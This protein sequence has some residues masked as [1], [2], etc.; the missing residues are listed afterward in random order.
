M[1]TFYQTTRAEVIEAGV[2]FEYSVNQILCF[3]ID[4]DISNSLAFGHKSNL[5]FKNK[6]D[7]LCDM[8]F[9]PKEISTNFQTFSEIRN[10]F[11][12]VQYVDNFT[13]CFEILKDKKSNILSFSDNKQNLIEEEINYKICFDFL[14]FQ[15][16]MWMKLILEKTH[17]NKN[18]MLKKTIVVEMLRTVLINKELNSESDLF[19]SQIDKLITEIQQDD[20]FIESVNQAIDLGNKKVK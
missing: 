3:I 2:A 11:A 8:K 1:T 6:I 10:K 4:I 7:I 14:C 16:A 9:V 13:K 15:L 19:S 20:W 17:F 12:H 18:Q 5:S